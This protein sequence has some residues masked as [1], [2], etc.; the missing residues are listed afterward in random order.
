MASPSTKSIDVKE[1]RRE[2]AGG[3]ALAVDV[4]SDEE[5]GKG[6]VPGA[7]HFP[8][9][10]MGADQEIKAGSRLLVIGSDGRAAEEAAS[11]LSERGYEA[12]A[13]QGSM[14]DWTSEDFKI[15]PTTD[16]DED[17]ELGLD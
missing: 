2:I 1:A 14:E 7:V 17:T 13:V 3:D 12:V 6:H 8:D 15:Q 10:E 9:G 5:W 11:R 16:P 4:R